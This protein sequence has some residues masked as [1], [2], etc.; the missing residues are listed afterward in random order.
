MCLNFLPSFLQVRLY[1]EIAD[2]IEELL[3][4]MDTIDTHCMRKKF[5]LH[6]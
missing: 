3:K 1:I 5:F 4:W 2:Y 6:K